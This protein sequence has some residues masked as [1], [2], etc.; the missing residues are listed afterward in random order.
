MSIVLPPTLYRLSVPATCPRSSI[1]GKRRK[2]SYIL[3]PAI[4]PLLS[5]FR[6]RSSQQ[7]QQQSQQQPSAAE[8]RRPSASPHL[9][10]ERIDRPKTCLR[11]KE[12]ILAR[13]IQD[14]AMDGLNSPPSGSRRSATSPRRG[15]N[16]EAPP[17]FS[18][19]DLKV[20]RKLLK[21]PTRFGWA[22]AFVLGREAHCFAYLKGC[23][24]DRGGAAGEVLRAA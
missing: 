11:D 2:R 24:V 21:T 4:N 19:E 5:E 12:A 23:R 10:E 7:R 20:E 3:T 22:S 6:A 15:Q 9:K 1:G 13:S 18:N 17:S 8:E 16:T 14:I